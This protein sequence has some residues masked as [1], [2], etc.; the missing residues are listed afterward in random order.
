MDANGS[1]KSP[2][3]SAGFGF[4]SGREFLAPEVDAHDVTACVIVGPASQREKQRR[5][6]GGLLRAREGKGWAGS[7]AAFLYFFLTET[8]LLFLFSVFKT[9]N[10][11][12]PKLFIKNCTNT[13]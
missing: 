2:Q 4:V 1:N 9:E 5:E 3:K 7:A 10:K 12:R 8:F 13:F 6:G 11:N